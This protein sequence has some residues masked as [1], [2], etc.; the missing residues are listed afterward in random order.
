MLAGA[1][2][3]VASEF[4]T[5]RLRLLTTQRGAAQAGTRRIDVEVARGPARRANAGPRRILTDQFFAA[6]A[7]ADLLH[8]FDLTGPLFAPRR[9]FVTTVHDASVAHGYERVRYAYKRLLQPWA[10]R[11]ARAVIADS[12]FARDEAVRC[13]GADPRRVTVIHAG[14]GL[15]AA[16]ANEART[17]D[18]PYLLY[19]GTMRENKNLPFL[20]RA[21]TRAAVDERL[22]IV[23][24]GRADNALRQT[25]ISSQV[26]ERVRV[27][28]NADDRELDRL[29]R[30]ATALLLPSRYEG[31]GFTPLEAMARGCPVL[32]SDIPAVR[33]VSG[34]GALLL[35]LEDDVAWAAA[36]QRVTR[37][38][39]LRAELRERGAATVSR[40]SWLE[41]ARDVCRVLES[42]PL[43]R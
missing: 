2:D 18:E 17:A 31:F 41:T 10:I 39:Q 23:S 22:L 1:L 42:V 35:P 33:E 36:I 30:G 8:F 12:A 19:V 13:F 32:A 40:Y 43:R 38:G 11:R 6:T 14:P 20:I 25:I 5:L 34:S 7:R 9:P 15:L 37:D 26:G 21:H 27:V 16:V 4:P 28:S 29:Y 3:E 24:P